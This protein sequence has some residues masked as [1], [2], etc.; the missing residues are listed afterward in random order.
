MATVTEDSIKPKHRG[1]TMNA[2][3]KLCLEEAI[4]MTTNSPKVGHSVFMTPK[5]ERITSF[6]DGIV[7]AMN[8]EVLSAYGC[9]AV[10]LAYAKYIKLTSKREEDKV[11]DVFKHMLQ[12]HRLLYQIAWK[13]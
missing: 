11:D 10:A 1:E 6:H 3:H 2:I 5:G 7:R 12:T 8:G 9:W 4:E 13:N